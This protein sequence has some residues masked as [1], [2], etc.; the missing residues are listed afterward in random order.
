[1]KFQSL[2]VQIMVT[3]T[4]S[5]I[6]LSYVNAGKINTRNGVYI[7]RYSDGSSSITGNL[8]RIRNSADSIQH[9]YCSVSGE[10][11]KCSGQDV[12][13]NSLG[14]FSVK[15]EFIKSVRD[16][17][18]ND[19]ISIYVDKTGSCTNLVFYRNSSSLPKH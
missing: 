12:N 9:L 4:L 6:T 11:A 1:M 10:M 15:K 17:T 7:T 13:Y 16:F 19:D 8:T 14:C 18:V 2:I 5:S 3:L